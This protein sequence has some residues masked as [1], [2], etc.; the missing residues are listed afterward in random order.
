MCLFAATHQIEILERKGIDMSGYR[1][2]VLAVGVCLVGICGTAVSG[3]GSA[4]PET[5]IGLPLLFEDDF[6][7]GN[8]DRWQPTDPK[9]W[10]VEEVDGNHVYWQFGDSKYEPKVR[11]PKNISWVKDL[12]VSDFV[13]E[14]KMQQMG[15]EYGHRDMCIF[16]GRQDAEHFYYVHIATK[17]DPHANSIFIVNGEPRVSIADERTTG[18]DWG[19]KPHTVRVV[20]NV[21]DG[22]IKVFFGNM[23]KPIM[24][25][26]D[27][28]FV[29]GTIGFGTFDDTGR[30]DDVRLWAKKAK[31]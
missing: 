18:T 17:A 31:D 27:K 7:S 20:R 13:L 23:E 5:M 1:F 10:K 11:S 14:A 4:A 16:F 24:I 21:D 8:A 3:G 6:E 25:A 19:Q 30:I 26:H 9:A 2:A 12:S 22:T 15:R 29:S 28:T